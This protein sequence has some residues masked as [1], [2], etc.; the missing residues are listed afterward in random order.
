MAV[1]PTDDFLWAETPADPGDVVNP[2][3]KRTGG[4]LPNTDVLAEEFN[5]LFRALGRWVQ[6]LDALDISNLL[7]GTNGTLNVTNDSTQLYRL[8]LDHSGAGRSGFAADEIDGNNFVRTDTMNL[9]SA[10]FPSLSVVDNSA[11]GGQAQAGAFFSKHTPYAIC[12]GRFVSGS[13]VFE[14]DMS[15]N[16]TSVSNFTSANREG[17]QFTVQNEPSNWANQAPAQGMYCEVSI[18][19]AEYAT[20][21]LTTVQPTFAIAELTTVATDGTPSFVVGITNRDGNAIPIA[22]IPDGSRFMAKVYAGIGAY[23]TE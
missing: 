9:P 3:A 14:S 13:F 17:F 4:F 15:S 5:Y 1:K 7:F 16:V 10:T 18:M 12:T 11:G 2:T 19:E 23:Y 20:A 21:Q 6:Y 22:N 8:E